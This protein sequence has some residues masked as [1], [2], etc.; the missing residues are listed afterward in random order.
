MGRGLSKLQKKILL[1]AY[2]NRERGQAEGKVANGERVSGA[3]LYSPEI[4]HE[5]WGWKPRIGACWRPGMRRP[6]P[7]ERPFSKA[8]VGERRYRSAVASWSR[9]AKRLER[10]GRAVRVRGFWPG[11]LDLTERGAKIAESIDLDS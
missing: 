8:E 9:A 2:E 6:D 5:H 4:L 1:L 3:D 11:A 7:W 10:R